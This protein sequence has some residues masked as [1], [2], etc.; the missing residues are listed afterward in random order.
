MFLNSTCLDGGPSLPVGPVRKSPPIGVGREFHEG[1]C[2]ESCGKNNAEFLMP[3][4]S[5]ENGQNWMVRTAESL[6]GSG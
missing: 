4:I 5:N 1:Q 6:C 3:S 2:T